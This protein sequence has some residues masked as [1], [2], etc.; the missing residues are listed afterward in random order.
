M[1]EGDADWQPLATLAPGRLVA[2]RFAAPTVAT[3]ARLTPQRLQELLALVAAVELGTGRTVRSP[4][5]D[6]AL[7]ALAG[8]PLEQV[9]GLRRRSRQTYTGAVSA[10]G[11][12]FL[13]LGVGPTG[14]AQTAVRAAQAA[15]YL[16]RADGALFSD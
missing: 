7:A 15:A 8:R 3:L 9:P 5:R 4:G 12:T 11:P 2:P 13:L 6:A 14:I 10:G 1:G 16:R